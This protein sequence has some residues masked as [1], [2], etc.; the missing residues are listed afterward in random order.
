MAAAAGGFAAE[1]LTVPVVI[2]EH[3]SA[4]A[5]AVDEETG[6]ETFWKLAGG[7]GRLE[8]NQLRGLMAFPFD[9]E[10]CYCTRCSDGRLVR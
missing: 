3:R 2:E 4:T 9:P 1:P 10:S 5:V 6:G 7:L 8:E